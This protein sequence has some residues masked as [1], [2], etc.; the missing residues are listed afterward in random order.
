MY[1]CLS[2]AS[3]A[4]SMGAGIMLTE[5]GGRWRQEEG[6]W[7]GGEGGGGEAAAAG[8][9]GRVRGAKEEGARPEKHCGTT[10]LVA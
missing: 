4:V 9:G 5:D 6:V 3:A 7:K 10:I 8:E 2:R 1:R